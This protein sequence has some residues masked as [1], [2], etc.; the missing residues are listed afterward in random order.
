[1]ISQETI[2]KLA[3]KYQTSEFPNII[4][5]YFQHLFLSNLYKIEGSQ[6]IMFK[7]GTALRII[8]GSPR[9]SED[10]DFS[11]F[12][13]PLYQVKN[14]VED[15]FTKVL[16]EIERI[17]IKVELGPKPGPTKEGYYGDASFKIYDYLPA[18]VSINVSARNE[19]KITPEIETIPND[20]A[21]TYNVYR[22]PQEFLI[23]EKI[24]ALLERKKTRDFYD[25]YYIMRKGL[26]TL[27]QKKR[28]TEIGNLVET[29]DID[30][31]TELSPF[32]P[33]DQQAIIKDFKT[34]LQSELK[35]Q[36]GQ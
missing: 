16:V 1:M 28:L 32:L 26:L 33:Q 10:L 20:F 35:R 25:I 24:D 4:R 13:T 19:R 21:P 14:F 23:E 12:N 5:E 2:Q 34:V 9:F 30:Y 3:I 22:L 8:Y 18:T 27:E 17:G 36:I 31:Q 6:N 7:G 15:L 11:A 29:M